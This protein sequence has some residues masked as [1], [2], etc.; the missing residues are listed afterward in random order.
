[1]IFVIGFEVFTTAKIHIVV[2]YIIKP[3]SLISDYE[4]FG[5]I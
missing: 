5:E 4:S 3:R 2:I 1:M